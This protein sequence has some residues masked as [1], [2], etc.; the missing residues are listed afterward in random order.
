MVQNEGRG[1]VK[2]K[3]GEIRI[4]G[5]GWGR[6]GG[7]DGRAMAGMPWNADQPGSQSHAERDWEEEGGGG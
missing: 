3:G 5:N 1:G 2:G 7:E 6:N 4:E